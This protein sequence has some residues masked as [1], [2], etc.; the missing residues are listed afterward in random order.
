LSFCR[1]KISSKK[2]AHLTTSDTVTAQKF[3]PKRAGGLKQ[4]FEI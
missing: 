2:T 3:Q 4:K 1:W